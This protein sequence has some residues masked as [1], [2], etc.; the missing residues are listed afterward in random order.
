MS[1]SGNDGLEVSVVSVSP[2]VPVTAMVMSYVPAVVLSRRSND[3][4]IRRSSANVSD[5]ALG[6]VAPFV[7]PDLRSLEQR[8]LSQKSGFVRRADDGQVGLDLGPGEI[9]VDQDGRRGVDVDV[10]SDAFEEWIPFFGQIQL[11]SRGHRRQQAGVEIDVA[12]QPG[13]VNRHLAADEDLVA[14]LG[15]LDLRVRDAAEIERRVV[16]DVVGRN[17]EVD[18][19]QHALAERHVA[20]AVERA[21][22]HVGVE[23]RQDDLGAPRDRRAR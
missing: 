11:A 4:K 2:G 23:P 20:G 12:R 10:E 15:D 9:V 7:Q 13:L 16:G 17:L 14:V 5:A 22:V 8:Q 3:G 19:A 18:V 1:G 21:A 6:L